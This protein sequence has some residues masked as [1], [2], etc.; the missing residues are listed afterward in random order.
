MKRIHYIGLVVAIGWVSI[1]SL[2]AEENIPLI[3]SIEQAPGFSQNLVWLGKQEPTEVENQRLLTIMQN[4]DKPTWMSGVE[5]FLSEY[6]KS[7]W[8]ASLHDAY[9][10]FCRETGRTTTALEQWEAAWALVKNDDSPQAKKLG[11]TILANW[12]ELLSSLGRVEKLK[13]LIAVGDQ[14]QFGNPQDRNRF[15][16]AK[17][18]CFL[19]QSHPGVAFRCGTFALK[20]VGLSLQPTNH[21]FDELVAIPSPTNGFSME[22]LIGIANQHGLDMVAVRR[23][24]GQDLIVPSVVHWR[25]NHYAAILA[26]QDD[27]YLVSDP[28]FGRE[29]WMPA[30]VINQEASGE[31]LIPAS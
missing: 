20:A 7:P 8:A 19:M 14:W 27:L 21:G 11:G 13:E 5:S 30:E 29:R 15:Q 9:A 16:G 4:L 17:N 6:P 18:S 10:S 1:S 24:K 23:T 22:Q 12:T 3:K 28:T 31:F 25:Q 26:Q 2:K